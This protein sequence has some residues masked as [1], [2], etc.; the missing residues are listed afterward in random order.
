MARRE[1]AAPAE[2]GKALPETT[3]RLTRTLDAP[4]AMVF[5]AWT[6]PEQI[7]EWWGPEGC[8]VPEYRIDARA[9]G[10]WRTVMR[11]PNGDHVVSGVFHEIN[12]PNRVVFTWAW[13]TD[14]E[15]GHETV[16]TV[17][18]RDLGER[19]ELTLTQREFET[20]ESC[21]AHEQGWTSSLT[22]LA[23]HLGKE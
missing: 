13:E 1:R 21:E 18:L 8:H 9:G 11:T 19:T 16:V 4:I 15:R 20:A 5:D 17:D 23:A 12:R 22:S 7:V 14:G 6:V 2:A 3:L 10:A